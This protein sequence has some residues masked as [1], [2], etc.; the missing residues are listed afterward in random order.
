MTE[1]SP[2][3][4]AVRAGIDSDLTHGAV[5]PPIYL[6]TTYTFAEFGVPR[7]FDY[8]RRGNPTRSMAADAIA[9]LEGG[10]GGV[11]TASGMGAITTIVTALLQPGDLLV[12]PHDCYGGSWRL[13]DALARKGSF[14]LVLADLTDPALAEEVI[15]TR[16]PTL[17]WVE[18]PSNPLLRIS[19]ISALSEQAHQVG[20]TV[21]VD[22]TFCTPLGQR[23]LELGAD[24]VV[25]SATKY[26]AGHSD[27]VAGAVVARDEERAQDL[28][29][30][31]NCLGVTGG[32]FDSYLLLRGLRTLHARMAL[33][34]S[35]GS[36]VVDLLAGHPAVAA[37]HHPRLPGHPGHALA[38]AQQQLFGGI[39]TF[40][41]HG[42]LD[43]AKTVMEAL[44]LFCPA[45]SLG[46]T[47]SLASHPGTMTHASMPPDV[48]LAA[49]ITPGMIRLSIG[50]EQIDDLL[51]DLRGALDRVVASAG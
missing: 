5:V 23:P 7:P 3:T 35:N 17:L 22:N 45:E 18:T 46:G 47:E 43:A 48:Q 8:A 11:V 31:A 29:W 19:D 13:F 10:A 38:S 4:R 28:A 32:A 12:A 33:H 30:W 15:R 44:T 37:V 40:E 21:V 50:I 2:I 34:E 27:V 26:L 1:P 42:G 49:G 36:A 14:E 20:A 16:R 24:L 39:V 51:A 41:V 6:S 25:H 9:G